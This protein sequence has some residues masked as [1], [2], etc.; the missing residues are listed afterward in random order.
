MR[1]MVEMGGMEKEKGANT[2][3]GEKAGEGTQALTG[4][5]WTTGTEDRKENVAKKETGGM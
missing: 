3:I 1:E 4:T 5:G 2:E